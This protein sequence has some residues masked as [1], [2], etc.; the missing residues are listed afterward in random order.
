MEIEIIEQPIGFHLL[1]LSSVVGGQ[2]YGEVGCRLMDQMWCIVQEAKLRT[3]GI[4]HWIYFG[5]D[6]MFVGVEVRDALETS[7]PEQLEACRCDLPRYAKHV[8][9]G[10]YQELPQ[11][12]QTLKAEL[13]AR[14][15]TIIMPSLEV[16][17]Y[18]CEDA[19]E[20]QAKTT[21]LLKLKP[22]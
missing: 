19:D 12:W 4:N 8:H 17:S 2:S 22:K 14:G 18:S 6:R 21:I 9:V 11:K 7:I 15:E 5:D 16:Y 13:T 20:T 10:P 3:T 1:G